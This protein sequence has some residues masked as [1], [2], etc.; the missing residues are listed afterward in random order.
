[1]HCVRNNQIH[2]SCITT[3]LFFSTD[4]VLD[5]SMSII[6]LCNTCFIRLLSFISSELREFNHLQIAEVKV[7][8]TVA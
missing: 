5:L 8:M 4:D 3:T 2:M 7:K 1:M 6:S